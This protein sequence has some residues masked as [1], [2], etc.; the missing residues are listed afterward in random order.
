MKTNVKKIVRNSFIGAGAVIIIGSLM[1]GL[2]TDE[3]L[4]NEFISKLKSKLQTFNEA[5]PEEKVYLQFDKTLY[6]PGE[7]IWFSAYVRDGETLAP[8]TKSEIL[9]AQLIDPKGNVS[10]EISLIARKGITN[11][12]FTLDKN[13]VGGLYKVKAFTNWQKNFSEES[14]FTKEVQVQ[15]VVIPHLLMKMDFTKKAYG[16]GDEVISKLN[17]NTLENKPL[18]DFD[19]NYTVNIDGKKLFEKKSQ[20]NS[21]G[22]AYLKFELPG[23]LTSNDGILN[24]MIDYEGRTESISR[25][26]PITLGDIDLAFYPE[27]G[28]LVEGL[29]SQV[30]FKAI[31]E[32][33][34]PADIEGVVFNKLGNKVAEF[35]SFHN[36]MGSFI[37]DYKI[38]DSYVAKITKPA[39]IDKEYALP[40]PLRRGW[41]MNVKH[42]GST[43]L[44]VI[45]HSTEEEQMSLICQIRGKIYYTRALSV[46]RG[47][48]SLMIPTKDLPIGIA[49]ITLFD[50]RNIERC[51]RMAFVNKDRQLKIDISTDKEKYQP[52]EKVHMTI[53]VSDERGLP[54][55]AS[56]SLAVVDDKLLSF[57]DDKSGNILS[58]LLL[59]SDIKS[60]VEEPAF[61]FNRKEDKADRALD[62]L[63]M[64]D[65]WR[66]FKWEQVIDEDPPVMVYDGEMARIE[67]TV[68]DYNSKPVSGAVIK[69][70]NITARTDDNGH[71]E[72]KNV[73]IYTQTYLNISSKGYAPQN[74]YVPGYNDDLR[75]TL[76]NKNL[77][78]STSRSAVYKR[79][80]NAQDFGIVPDAGGRMKLAEEFVPAMVEDMP[81]EEGK[82]DFA[83]VMIDGIADVEDEENM[84]IG[85]NE[86]IPDDD[87]LL[88]EVEAFDWDNRR[89][90]KA[91][92]RGQANNMLY[93]RAREFNSPEYKPNDKIE[94][95]TDF[96][97]TI[98]WDGNLQVDRSGKV[99]VEFCNSDEV[100]SFRATVEGIGVGLPGHT[101][102]KYFTQLPFSMFTKVPAEVV[103]T[104]EVDIPLTLKNNTSRILN[105][106]ISIDASPAFKLLTPVSEKQSIPAHSA[107]TIYLNYRVLNQPGD[108]NL[109]I[110]FKS[111][112]LKDA[113]SQ[114]VHVS[115]KGF[116]VSLAFS[117]QDVDKEYKLNINNSVEGSLTASLT[118]YPSVVTDLMSGIESI[119][120][121]PYG[122]FEQ[123]STSNYPNVMAMQYIKESNYNDASL[124]AS[125]E[126]K[127]DKGYKRLTSYETKEKGYEWFGSAPGHEAL[128]AYGLMQF[129]DMKKVYSVDE[130][131]IDRTAK[132]LLSKRDGKG[133]FIR[134]SKALDSF[135]RASEDV[136]NAYIVYALSEAA[137]RDQILKELEQACQ[138]SRKSADSYQLALITNALINFKDKRSE[139]FMKELLS[140]QNSDGSWSADHSITRSG[141]QS[142][143]IETTALAA[144]A[145]LKSD[146]K[147]V[148]ALGKAV[149]F[150]VGNR[151]GYGGFGSTQG[152]IL[153]LKALT[154]YAKFS[155]K[156]SED[157][158][159]EVYVGARKVESVSYKAGQKGA[160]EIKGLEKY[161]KDGINKIRIKYVGVKEPLPYSVAV[162]YNTSLPPSSPECN[163]EIDAELTQKTCHEGETVRLV[164]TLKNSKNVGQP[165]T[166][167]VVGIPSGLS[168]QPWQLKELQEKG[169]VDFYE[170][171]GN[172][173]IFYFRDMAPNEKH[174]IN[175]DLKAEIPGQYDAPAS[176]GYLYYTKEYKCWV[177]AGRITIKK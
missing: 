79:K 69:T 8:S 173:V 146:K 154:Q 114:Q 14:F 102:K 156:T 19:F 157:G 137:Y 167:A 62:Y 174:V 129:H 81:L 105:G 172:N 162:D 124:L 139:S 142:L 76:Y 101:E 39:G 55:P 113:F 106:T 98:F 158:S 17:L 176:A 132:W 130:K 23:E 131:M 104:D 147:D 31:N 72:L 153:A 35:S 168:P 18:S 32:F 160:I 116:P 118:A 33:N 67:G 1:P 93:Y 41:V 115:S 58:T 145:I 16:P 85:D 22:E 86:E 43:A 122:C 144:L 83:V 141:G 59:E 92:I 10:K 45:I 47:R 177:S 52:R 107:K 42:D 7:T 5:V 103:S 61:Y 36:G 164:T 48:N 29:E 34:K 40:E 96:R 117:G 27:G 63:L 126:P 9:H 65:G 166:M 175:L 94:Y 30:A 54:V 148:N 60:K 110:A 123:T 13:A 80:A 66:R 127:L 170:V 108:H 134:N 119:I 171:S 11:G 56:L 44:N 6:K 75:V 136:T 51:E 135:G 89:D 120:R 77:Y 25:S 3:I 78:G 109:R 57:A 128:T 100:S 155:K 4:I 71:F 150:I 73:D 165:M 88:G 70:G 28:D 84:E 91:P 125:I 2:P 97:S 74:I 121:E 20:T 99:E 64:T 53:Q 138:T 111:G 50:G 163:V 68:L 149:K 21:E 38:G 49:Q 133:G 159:I 37:L 161:L 140:K 46:K 169:M 151:S 112:G 87:V 82:G 24:V 12:D 152:T 143:Q 15:S 95:R 90:L 26:V